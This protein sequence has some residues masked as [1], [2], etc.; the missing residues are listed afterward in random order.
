MLSPTESKAMLCVM[1]D[2]LPPP[3][4]SSSKL[5]ATAWGD[6][7]AT[8]A[9]MPRAELINASSEIEVSSEFNRRELVSRYKPST[10]ASP[11]FVK[12]A[13]DASV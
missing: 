11:T 1:I 12:I 10:K 9:K 8:S 7:S 5:T 2:A 13:S 3:S 6:T 4:L